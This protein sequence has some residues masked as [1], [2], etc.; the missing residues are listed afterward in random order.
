M[1][2]SKRAAQELKKINW[3][4]LFQNYD[5]DDPEELELLEDLARSLQG[6]M[7]GLLI[8]LE[9]CTHGGLWKEAKAIVHR[10]KSSFG[11][12]GMSRAST[13]CA[14][15]QNALEAGDV[16]EGS[17][18]ITKLLEAQKSL[19]GGLEGLLTRIA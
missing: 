3:D 12:I 8:Q 14:E 17:H 9:D 6:E 4:F 11:N 13:L 16:A 15:I 5:F 10:M 1:A 7:V 18:E 2:S 19:L